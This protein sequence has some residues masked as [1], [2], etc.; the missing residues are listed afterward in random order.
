MDYLEIDE[1]HMDYYY[2]D[3]DE[4]MYYLKQDYSK[5]REQMMTKL[6]SSIDE[7]NKLHLEFIGE[8]LT[9]YITDGVLPAE[10]YY[11]NAAYIITLF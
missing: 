10:D 8:W 5:I 11:I 1:G 7:K 2:D 9:R 4:Y 3:D 6:L